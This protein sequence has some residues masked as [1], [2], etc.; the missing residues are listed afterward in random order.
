MKNFLRN[1][2]LELVITAMVGVAV[3]IIELTMS[4]RA[5][6]APDPIQVGGYTQC[7]NNGFY[8][9]YFVVTNSSDQPAKVLSSTYATVPEQVFGQSVPAHGQLTQR[10]TSSAQS[11][12][13]NIVTTAGSASGT[14]SPDPSCPLASPPPPISS[15]SSSP[16]SHPEQA[17]EF[18][19]LAPTPWASPDADVATGDYRPRVGTIRSTT[20]QDRVVADENRRIFERHECQRLRDEARRVRE[21]RL[22]PDDYLHD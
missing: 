19:P 20:W 18:F 10:T 5:N 11:V 13:E 3:L 14:L 4:E 15:V 21:G 1:Y 12:T 9:A 6:A 17:D 7:L 2:W 16:R 22:L 8:N